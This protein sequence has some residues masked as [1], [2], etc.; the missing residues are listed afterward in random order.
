MFRYEYHG[1]IDEKMTEI[2]RNNFLSNPAEKQMD[3]F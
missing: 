3:S 1:L 2:Y